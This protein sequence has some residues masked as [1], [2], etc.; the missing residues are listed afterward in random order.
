MVIL[1]KASCA[2]HPRRQ[3]VDKTMTIFL[4]VYAA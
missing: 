1:A 3:L 4:I 2:A